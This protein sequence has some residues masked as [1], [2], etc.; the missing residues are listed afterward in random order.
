[1]SNET[2]KKT[3]VSVLLLSLRIPADSNQRF[4]VHIKIHKTKTAA[5]TGGEWAVLFVNCVDEF[6]SLA[7]VQNPNVNETLILYN[8]K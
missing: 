2:K 7:I 8:M 1:M 3:V 6:L 4:H 5:K